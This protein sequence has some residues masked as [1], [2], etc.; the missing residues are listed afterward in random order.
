MSR[1]VFARRLPRRPDFARASLS[2]AA[3]GAAKAGRR[4]ASHRSSRPGSRSPP[5]AL[6]S[7]FVFRAGGYR[8]LLAVLG[9]LALSL[10]V[11][12]V[13]ARRDVDRVGDGRR[14]RRRAGAR[15]HCSGV[16]RRQGPL[17]SSTRRAFALGYRA[18]LFAETVLS[19]RPA[20]RR[21]ATLASLPV[22]S[23]SPPSTS[24]VTG[25]AIRRNGT[26][27]SS[28]CAARDPAVVARTR[29]SAPRWPTRL[30]EQGIVV[31]SAA[32]IAGSVAVM[33]GGAYMGER[34]ATSEQDFEGRIQH[35][36]DGLG[37]LSTPT[38]MAA[39]QGIGA[40]SEELLLR[41]ARCRRFPEAIASRPKRA[42]RSWS[43]RARAIRSASASSSG[44]RSACRSRRVPIR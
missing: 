18:A 8:S 25:A 15:R 22:G 20:I 24:P 1:D 6:A 9:V 7:F 17:S 5:A 21:V 30:R 28:S 34:F 2:A 41:R 43:C 16:R 3:V 31:A 14:H 29:S 23:L 10:Q 12:S 40:I 44:S 19:E 42:M 38:R 36:R 27:P 39:G 11:S 32:V 13:G 33:L 26:L 37:L 35:W 4:R